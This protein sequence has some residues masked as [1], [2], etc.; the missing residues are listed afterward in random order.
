VDEP[1]FS[2]GELNLAISEAM[3]EAFPRQV[4]VRGEIQQFH[5]SRNQHVYFE[6]VEKDGN[7][8]RIRA[9]LRVALFR[10]DRPAVTR[11]LK[12]VP[13]VKL[14][15][16]VEVRI[17]GR[18]DFYP[19][20]GRLQ[21]VMNG[22]DP[23]FTVGRLAADRERVLRALAA[24]GLLRRNAEHDPGP[25]PLRVGLV[26]SGGSA[27]YHD[28]LQELT[29]SGYAFRVAHVDVRVQGGG[30][31][32][33]IAYALRRLGQLDLDVVVVVRGGGARSDLAP[34]DSEIVARAIAELPHPVFTG[35]GHEVDRSVADEVAHTSCKT[36]T[37]AAGLL[38]GRVDE[39]CARLSRLSH[40]ISVRARSGCTM[41]NRDLDRLTGRI[42][43]AAPAGLQ[44]ESTRLDDR[45]RRAAELGRR[46][47][48]DAARVLDDRARRTAQLG[49]RAT[50]D[51]ARTLG[52]HEHTLVATATRGT[53]AADAR[54]AV[55]AARL[56]GLDPQRVLERGYTITRDADGR[57]LTRLTGVEAGATLAVEFADGT[58]VT[59]VERTELPPAPPHESEAPS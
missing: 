25:V 40:R 23:V 29:A 33:R 36:P 28:F 17:R 56:R 8:D 44:H 1:T 4:W 57:V 52:A 54:L 7:R 20:T 12:E 30:A 37:A 15:D 13:G 42:A 3:V 35:I 55:A 38:I 16:G 50:R 31:S 49:R 46:A 53:R 5:A 19:P 11:A 6:L 45:A 18:V 41:A 32:R 39:F 26:T 2:V 21:L 14:T 51:A 48:R 24:E 43:R 34:F 59:R 47:T 10:N 22:I 58:A 27:A 9:A